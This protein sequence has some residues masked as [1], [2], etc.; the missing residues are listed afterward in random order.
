VGGACLVGVLV[1]TGVV[2]HF[3]FFELRSPPFLMVN[4]PA[5][6]AAR[7]AAHLHFFELR[8]VSFIEGESKW[9]AP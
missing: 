7:P 6:S 2:A 8:F 3:N 9:R 4:R 5:K 1:W